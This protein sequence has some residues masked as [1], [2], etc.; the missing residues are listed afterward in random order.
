MLGVARGATF[1]ASHN[2]HLGRSEVLTDASGSF[3]WRASNRAFDRA[4]VVDSI[5]GLNDGFLRQYFDADSGVLVQLE[6]VSR[7][8][9]GVEHQLV[10]AHCKLTDLEETP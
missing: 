8:G 6:S 10:S 1:D 3:A 9:C 7:R 5:G 2:D 4:V